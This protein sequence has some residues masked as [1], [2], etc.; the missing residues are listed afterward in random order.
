MDWS[1]YTDGLEEEQQQVERKALHKRETAEALIRMLDG[2][3]RDFIAR[4][5]GQGFPG[6]DKVRLRVMTRPARKG[7]FGRDVPATFAQRQGRMYSDVNWRLY[8]DGSWGYYSSS[9]EDWNGF[10]LRVSADGEILSWRGASELIEIHQGDPTATYHA[11][12]RRLA[13][14]AK[15]TGVGL[16]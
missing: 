9:Y 2:P 11:A 6:S 7:I 10:D 3:A 5:E 4:A 12:V 8:S 1:Q 13:E 14:L 15:R 16:R